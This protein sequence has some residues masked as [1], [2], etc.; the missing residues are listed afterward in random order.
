[1]MAIQRV[2]DKKRQLR[3]SKD[4]EDQLKERRRTEETASE[5]ALRNLYNAV[6]LLRMENGGVGIEP[7]EIGGRP[8]QAT[9]IH[10]RMMELLTNAG[11]P[12]VHGSVTPRKIMER[13]KLGESPSDAVQPLLGVKVSD[14]VDAF[15]SFLQPPRLLTADAIRKGITSGIREGLFAYA[16]GHIPSLDQNG[17]YQ[18]NPDKI[19]IGH[20]IPEDEIDIESGFLI[21]PLAIPVP[22]PKPGEKPLSDPSVPAIT[23]DILET[24]E[25]GIPPTGTIPS[26]DKP[27]VIQRKFKATRDQVFK[28][29]PAIANLADKSDGGQVTIHVEGSSE[30]GYDPSWLRNAFDEPLNEA[31]IEFD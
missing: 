16:S 4:Q 14:I 15:Y 9:E 19:T 12:K 13:V 29:F 20:Y 24:P 11:T 23:G 8:L 18:V 31:D 10:Q 7:V 2:E 26:A 25:K 21:S 3:L 28:A 5:H 22:T 27:K 30:N 17:K 1:L 6:W